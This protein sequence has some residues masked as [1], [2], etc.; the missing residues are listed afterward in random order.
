MSAVF[1]YIIIPRMNCSNLGRME[2]N[3]K[4]KMKT[5]KNCQ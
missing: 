3:E 1:V 2:L 5:V 4:N